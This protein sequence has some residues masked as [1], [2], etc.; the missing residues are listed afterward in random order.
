M[1]ELTVFSFAFMRQN[2]LLMSIEFWSWSNIQGVH[3]ILCFFEDF[4]IYSGH[5][6]LPVSPRF[7]CV[8]TMAGQTPA[9][10]QNLQ[11]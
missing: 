9:L 6:P 10:Q 1:G 5:R 8:Y 3:E 2:E 11:S 7:Q 4:K